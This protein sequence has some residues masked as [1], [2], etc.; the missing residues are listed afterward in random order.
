MEILPR[1]EIVLCSFTDR[2]HL[3]QNVDPERVDWMKI[4][5]ITVICYGFKLTYS[6]I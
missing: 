6:P 4:A 3:L 2:N 1:N 5:N